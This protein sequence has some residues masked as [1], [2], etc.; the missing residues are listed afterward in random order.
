MRL[1]SYPLKWTGGELWWS[2]KPVRAFLVAHDLIGFRWLYIIVSLAHNFSIL[3]PKTS[4]WPLLES[5]C[6]PLHSLSFS[7]GVESEVTR[8]A[9]K[10]IETLNPSC[11]HRLAVHFCPWGQIQNALT[12]AIKVPRKTSCAQWLDQVG[13]AFIIEST[14]KIHDQL[15]TGGNSL[16]GNWFL[17][18]CL[19]SPHKSTQIPRVPARTSMLGTPEVSPRSTLRFSTQRHFKFRA[20]GTQEVELLKTL[21]PEYWWKSFAAWVR[22]FWKPSWLPLLLYWAHIVTIFWETASPYVLP[23][24]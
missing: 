7:L 8:F 21:S 23:L 6:P 15:I 14:L 18:C 10:A 11:A 16:A 4:F 1:F 13:N 22:S 20:C 3:V 9:F 12:K 5:Y 19:S 24:I 17:R 2:Q